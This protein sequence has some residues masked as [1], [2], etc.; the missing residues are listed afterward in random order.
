MRWL[1]FAI[2]A[3][4]TVTIQ[5]AIAPR[6]AILGVYPDFLVVIVV[7][8]ALYARGMDPVIAAWILGFLAD[9]MTVEQMGLMSL[10]YALAAY[11]VLAIR[12]YLFRYHAITRFA[13]TLAV[14]LGIRL[15]WMAYAQA[16][17]PHASWSWGGWILESLFVAI[18]SAVF[19]VPTTKLLLAIPQALGLPQR[20][21]TFE[22]HVT[23]GD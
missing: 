19:A 9:L 2:I 20:K 6:L 8:Y 4:L 13:I 23:M 3:A 17:Y 7:F 22:G 15:M 21:Y 16:L 14:C 5:S 10:S 12:E 18:Y 11:V 1:A